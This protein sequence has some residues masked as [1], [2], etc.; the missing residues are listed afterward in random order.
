MRGHQ[1]G[2][3]VFADAAQEFHHFQSRVGV[4]V[5]GGFVGEDDIGVVEQGAGD[6]NALLFAA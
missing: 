1:H 6:G 4:E 2:L 5:A 3:A